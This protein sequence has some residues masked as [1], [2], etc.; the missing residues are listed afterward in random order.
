[1]TREVVTAGRAFG[2]AVGI[3][4]AEPVDADGN[5]ARL[6]NAAAAGARAGICLPCDPASDAVLTL[7]VHLTGYSLPGT[8]RVLVNGRPVGAIARAGTQTLKFPV[9]RD[10]LAGR[11][12]CEVIL[13]VVPFLPTAH[14]SQDS[15]TLGLAVSAVDL[16][17]KGAE[18][19]PPTCPRVRPEPDWTAAASCLKRLGKGATLVVPDA[20]PP[21]LCE[22]VLQALAHPDRR[23]PDADGVT[24]P[25]TDA[26][27][28]YAT[29]LE[30]GV[31]WYNSTAE[32]RT[33]DGAQV[34]PRGSAFDPGRD[35]TR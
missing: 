11:K 27:G 10:L 29:Q 13:E 31:L 33:V 24:L 6:Y 23:L 35:V 3:E 12:L 9:P 22:A 14:G 17:A 32:A 28:V 19:D 18:A 21:A 7:E 30:S 34:P 2:L 15:R 1:V 8:N 26:D 4:P 16:C 25:N 20:T 5:V